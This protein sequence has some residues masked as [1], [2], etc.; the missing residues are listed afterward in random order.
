MKYR[1]PEYNPLTKKCR[2]CPKEKHMYHREG[3][4]LNRRNEVFN[5]CRHRRGKLLENVKT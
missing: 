2:I 3:S 1:G 5:T 4:S